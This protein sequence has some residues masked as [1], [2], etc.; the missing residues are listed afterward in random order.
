MEKGG[1]SLYIDGQYEV[2]FK[3]NYICIFNILSQ[4]W[5]LILGENYQYLENIQCICV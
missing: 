1:Q 5:Y 4:N 3:P 2:T